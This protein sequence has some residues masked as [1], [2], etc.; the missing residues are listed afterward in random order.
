LVEKLGDCMA[1][2]ITEF[3]WDEFNTGHLQ[4]AHPHIDLEMLEMIVENSKRWKAEGRD[5]F[6]KKVYSVVSH[7]LRVYFNVKP[8]RIA[9]IFSVR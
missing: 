6:G 1:I 2:T 7:G 4:A 9:R 3:E 5:R 8:G